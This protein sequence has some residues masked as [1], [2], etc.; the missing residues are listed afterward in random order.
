MIARTAYNQTKCNESW[1]SINDWKSCVFKA[2]LY[3]I[4]ICKYI[5]S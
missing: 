1:N 3:N 5:L 2:H 4:I